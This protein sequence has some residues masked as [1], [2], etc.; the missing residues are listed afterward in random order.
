MKLNTKLGGKLALSKN[1]AHKIWLVG[2]GLTEEEQLKALKGS[3]FIPFSQFP[4][5]RMCKD[6]FYHTT[7]ATMSPTS[8]ENMDSC[9]NWLPRR[10]MSAWRVAGILHALEGWNVHTNQSIYHF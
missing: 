9:E 2:D 8:F 5:K 7:P 4:P 6:C 1:Y 3:L 10:A